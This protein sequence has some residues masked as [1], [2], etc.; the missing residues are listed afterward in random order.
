VCTRP[1]PPAPAEGPG[2]LSAEVL[3]FGL[4]T[5]RA[6][7]DDEAERLHRSL[8]R[9]YGRIQVHNEEIYGRIRAL[10]WFTIPSAE[11]ARKESFDSTNVLYGDVVGELQQLWDR[12]ADIA[13]LDAVAAQLQ[14]LRINVQAGAYFYPPLNLPMVLRLHRQQQA[15]WKTPPVSGRALLRRL[16][17]L[18][19]H[20]E[21]DE[22]AS[23][24]YSLARITPQPQPQVPRTGPATAPESNDWQADRS[25]YDGWL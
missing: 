9:R 24:V 5:L 18:L 19:D 22:K 12:R 25:G 1:A 17:Y 13:F 4:G 14:S 21:L 8:W 16:D 15:L 3:A 11:R 10:H 6:R 23:T 2:L 7:N 20:I